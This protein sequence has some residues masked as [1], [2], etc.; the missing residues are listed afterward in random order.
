MSNEVPIVLTVNIG[1]SSLRLAI[2]A[3]DNCRVAVAEERISPVPTAQPEL[4]ECFLAKSGITTAD[5]VVHRVVHGGSSL[6]D[7]CLIDAGVEAEILR[8]GSSAPLHNRVALEW[9]R[10]A[11]QSMDAP[12]A[13]VFDTAFFADLP[14]WASGYALP[15]E[16]CERSSIRRFGFHGL[17]HQDMLEEWQR[18]G[19]SSDRSERII[20]LQLGSGCSMAATRDGRPVETSMGFSPLEGLM[21]STRCGDLDPMVVLQLLGEGG[22]SLQELDWILN[23]AS[24]LR[25]VSGTTSDMA[26]LLDSEEP[27]ERL[28]VEMFCHRVIKYLGAYMAVLGGVDAILFG[29]GIGQSAPSIRSR[30]LGGLSW[31]GILLDG[32]RNR[33]IESHQGGVISADGS[34]VEVRVVPVREERIMARSGAALLSVLHTDPVETNAQPGRS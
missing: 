18:H 8:L 13:A 25:G 34:R 26:V 21:M 29:G 28:A 19:R 33:E 11:R 14:R 2:F 24:G 7:A 3:S 17:A 12:Q 5:I 30:V 31:A 15:P 16:I 4:L 20:S 27:R 23:H 22:F 1:S 6:R 10:A 9:I 32:K